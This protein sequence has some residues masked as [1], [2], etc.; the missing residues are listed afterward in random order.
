M[1]RPALQVL[2]KPPLFA[3]IAA[4]ALAANYSGYIKG[5]A[6]TTPSNAQIVI[7]LAP[8]MLIL[9]GLVVYKERIN[10]FQ[11]LGFVVAII[12]FGLFY[13]DQISQLLTSPENYNIG[14]AW[15]I[16]AALAWVLFAS[17]QKSLVQQFHAQG[18]NLVIYLVP[19]ILM[20]PLVDFGALAEISWKVWG[21]LIFLGLNTL[22]AY[23]AIAEAFRFIPANKVGIIVTINPIITIATMGL[24]SY[25]GVDWIQP[26]RISVYGLLGAVLIVTGIIITIVVQRKPKKQQVPSG[27]WKLGFK[28]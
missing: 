19:T 9:V 16:G 25:I 1:E 20:I 15:V 17:F 21:L 23:G 12:G 27:K 6:L 24:L 28:R 13:R 5:L 8:L 10:L 14:V 7:Q 26:E 22:L 3:I 4:I 18:L 11:A 2:R